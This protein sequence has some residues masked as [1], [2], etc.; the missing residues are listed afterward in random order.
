[1]SK[2][3]SKPS[4]ITFDCYGTL[5]QWYQAVTSGVSTVLQAH[6]GDAGSMQTE[7]VI[8]DFRKEA[9]R[10]QA[11]PVYQPYK[12]ILTAALKVAL[13]KQG[14]DAAPGDGDRFLSRLRAV[15]PHPETPS[16]LRRLGQHY[17]LAVISNSDDDLIA[18]TIALLGAP[19][20]RVVTAQQARAY[21]PDHQL[22]R[23]AHEALGVTKDQVIHVGMGPYTDLKVCHEMG[24][25][26]IWI[27]R[28]GEPANPDWPA[29]AVLP[30]LTGLAE[31][32]GCD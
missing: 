7:E 31:V 11:D 22:F 23:Y 9:Y 14:L 29:D 4:V 16:V 12:T 21:K 18:G 8:G 10:L 28:H 27:N 17:R 13:A 6:R 15:P 20:D 1:V 3:E 5:V 30:D 2:F 19:L 26:A 25:R 32:L 24:I